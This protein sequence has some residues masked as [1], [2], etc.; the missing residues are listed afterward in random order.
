[1]ENKNEKNKEL[2]KKYNDKKF[3]FF[4]LTT[5]YQYIFEV[6]KCCGYGEWV[7][8]HKDTPLSRLYENI[9]RQLGNLKPLNLYALSESGEKIEILCDWDCSV[10][11]LITEKSAFFRPIYPLPASA[12]YRIYY[13][14][15]CSCKK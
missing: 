6:T 8:V 10:R 14:E 3:D 12:I 15:E 2:L 1:M 7:T 4:R 11:K 5:N 9:H 13:D